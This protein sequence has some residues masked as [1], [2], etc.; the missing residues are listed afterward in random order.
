MSE[1]V[2]SPG[3]RSGVNCTRLKSSD[4]AAASVRTI[5]VLATPGTPSSSTC[6]L[7][8]RAMTSP[9]TT[10]SCPTTA[11][12]TSARSALSASLAASAECSELTDLPFDLVH[13]SGQGDH[14]LVVLRRRPVQRGAEPLRVLT[15]PCGDRR[16]HLLAVR[17]RPQPE[18]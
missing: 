5:S 7:H 6:P 9:V 10:A 12:D 4:S 16:H 14:A 11:L 18:P 1:P 3:I 15:R 17:A 8:S 2:T 13:V